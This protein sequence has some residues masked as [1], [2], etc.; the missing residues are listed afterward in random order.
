MEV[1]VDPGRV[2]LLPGLPL[3]VAVLREVDAVLA[4]FGARESSDS[5]SSFTLQVV[6][7]A[8]VTAACAGV[9]VLRSCP[10]RATDFLQW[11]CGTSEVACRRWPGSPSSAPAGKEDDVHKVLQ[12][13]LEPSLSCELAMAEDG[14]FPSAMFPSV[15]SSDAPAPGG[16]REGGAAARLRP[17]LV[18]VLSWVSRDLVVFPVFPGVFC[19]VPCG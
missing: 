19:N 9:P 3:C 5:S 10:R 2:V 17:A 1:V 11:W 6:V 8:L 15:A 16:R 18:W 7:K 13:Q 12:F 4:D 14:D